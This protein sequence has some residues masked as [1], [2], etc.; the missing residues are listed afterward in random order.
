MRKLGTVLKKGTSLVISCSAFILCS[1]V[2]Y[3]ALAHRLALSGEEKRL[4]FFFFYYGALELQIKKEKQH[5]IE[6]YL[7][8]F[9][10]H[11]SIWN[12]EK[13]LKSM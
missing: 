7:P 12:K 4:F 10:L 1:K 6:A 5:I 13:W 11:S 9:Q 3:C 8:S 2:D